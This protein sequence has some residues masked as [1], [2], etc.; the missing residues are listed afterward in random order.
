MYPLLDDGIG[1]GL[2]GVSAAPCIENNQKVKTAG[3]PCTK[4]PR[5]LEGERRSIRFV[6]EEENVWHE[7]P[8]REELLEDHGVEWDVMFYRQEDLREMKRLAKQEVRIVEL[9]TDDCT[10]DSFFHDIRQVDSR[11]LNRIRI[12]LNG[13][14]PSVSTGLSCCLR[15]LEKHSNHYAATS[16]NK[17]L[18]AKGRATVLA[19]QERIQ[20]QQNSIP[21]NPWSSWRN[22]IKETAP[23][24]DKDDFDT[25]AQL[26]KDV[27]MPSVEAA[28]QRAAFDELEALAI[29]SSEF[30]Q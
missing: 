9:I 16:K 25:V 20:K 2:L 18:R 12:F 5:A 30:V 10:K 19:G 8:S 27:A 22:L 28:L 7:I 23:D 13:D 21:S 11:E 4:R 29:H 17:G 26:Y 14:P 3:S 6:P 24:S 15:G 1:D